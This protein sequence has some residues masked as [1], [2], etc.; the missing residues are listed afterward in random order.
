MFRF[1]SLF[2]PLC[3][4]SESFW[5]VSSRVCDIRITQNN[6][7]HPNN[8]G[9]KNHVFVQ[10]QCA[11]SIRRC[12]PQPV[13]HLL[14]ETQRREDEVGWGMG[15]KRVL[16]WTSS[17]RDDVSLPYRCK[18]LMHFIP[19]VPPVPEW[20]VSTDQRQMRK[21]KLIWKEHMRSILML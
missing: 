10:E 8:D 3:K 21:G 15:R 12:A 17:N 2:L 11:R 13:W 4:F 6:I 16:S 20:R 18:F 19:R 9:R 7:N 1:R 5:H 14:C